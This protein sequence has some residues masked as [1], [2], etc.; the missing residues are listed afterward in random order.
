MK[1]TVCELF[2]GVGGFRCGLNNIKTV[3]DCKKKEKWK[4]VWFSQWEP[5]EKKTQYAH[6]CYVYHFGTSLDLDG[7]DDEH[8]D[9]VESPLGLVYSATTNRLYVTGKNSDNNPCVYVIDLS[10]YRVLY[11]F[12]LDGA[13]DLAICGTGTNSD[14]YITDKDGKKIIRLRSNYSW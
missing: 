14:L 10:S 7:N 3:S 9:G 13:Y 8:I 12:D 6:D 1:K 11:S 2:A 5:A 4:T